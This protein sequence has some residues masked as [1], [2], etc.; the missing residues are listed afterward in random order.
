MIVNQVVED[1]KS[2]WFTS[3]LGN[4]AVE[5]K[6]RWFGFFLRFLGFSFSLKS[7]VHV[8]IESDRKIATGLVKVPSLHGRSKIASGVLE[9]TT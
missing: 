6:S 1:S 3:N 9:T 5:A 8:S 4:H 7:C 2:R